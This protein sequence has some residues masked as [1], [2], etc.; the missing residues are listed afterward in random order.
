MSRA[1]TRTVTPLSRAEVVKM[2]AKPAVMTAS[3]RSERSVLSVSFPPSTCCVF[4]AR[5]SSR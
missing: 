1:G 2:M 4:D 3:E 5:E